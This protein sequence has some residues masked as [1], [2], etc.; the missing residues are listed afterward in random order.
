MKVSKS[1][2]RSLALLLAAAVGGLSGFVAPA[3]AANLRGIRFLSGDATNSAGA[4][5]TSS[6][7]RVQY[8]LDNQGLDHT[9]Q[10][11]YSVD[12]WRTSS[13]ANA[14]FG[15]LSGSSEIWNA[16]ASVPGNSARFVYSFSC[17]DLGQT[18]IISAQTGAIVSHGVTARDQVRVATAHW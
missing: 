14:T 13:T 17:T 16:S 1:R 2:T 3:S 15:S 11:T 9:C 10:L 5:G 18:Q 4:G 6:T 12:G 8:A 7:L